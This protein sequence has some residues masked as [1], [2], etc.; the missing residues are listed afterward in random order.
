MTGNIYLSL[1]PRISFLLTGEEQVVGNKKS[2]MNVT[3]ASL[4][5]KGPR[6]K[7]VE[8]LLVVRR[9]TSEMARRGLQVTDDSSL[10]RAAVSTFTFAAPDEPH[11]MS[12]EERLDTHRL[13]VDRP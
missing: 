3:G 5:W 8:F 12:S 7:I 2:E 9:P 6:K 10:C 13:N 11:R 1:G 4:D